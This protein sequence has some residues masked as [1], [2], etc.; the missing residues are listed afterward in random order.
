MDQDD[1]RIFLAGLHFYGRDKPS[2]NAKS[3]V[4]PLEVLCLTPRGCLSRV[5]RG[6]LSPFADR[7]SPNFGGCFIAAPDG[8]GCLAIFGKGEVGE[9]AKGVKAFGAFP[10][11]ADR[12][13][14]ARASSLRSST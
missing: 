14:V 9:V 11:C 1:H 2:L 8:G 13:K 12:V 3:I 10:D 5:I 4:R 7:S 6:Q